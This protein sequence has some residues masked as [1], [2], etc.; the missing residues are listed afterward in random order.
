MVNS[1][2][3]ILPSCSDSGAFQSLELRLWCRLYSTSCSKP[4]QAE[5]LTRCAAISYGS[6]RFPVAEALLQEVA[7]QPYIHNCQVTV[8]EGRHT[9][10]YCVFFKRHCRLQVN[11]LLRDVVVM[12]IGTQ[13]CRVVNM[14]ARDSVIADY[15]VTQVAQRL[16]RRG[17]SR[18]PRFIGLVKPLLAQ[19]HHYLRS[20]IPGIVAVAGVT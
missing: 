9:Y 12:R 15:I 17:R 7:L 2:T 16:N 6:P 5:M 4:R 3:Y 18:L 8:H 11:A 14:R 20:C 19:H 1:R 10:N 13:T